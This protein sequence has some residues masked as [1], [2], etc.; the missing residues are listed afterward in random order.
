MNSLSIAVI[1][2]LVAV[3]SAASVSS[4]YAFWKR[5]DTTVC[6]QFYGECLSRYSN[7]AATESSTCERNRNVSFVEAEST[8]NKHIEELLAT[9]AGI[10]EK[11]NCGSFNETAQKECFANIARNNINSLKEIEN[12]SN[13]AYSKRDAQEA[14]ANVLGNRCLGDVNVEMSSAIQEI[15]TNLRSCY[16][17][18]ESIIPNHKWY[19]IKE[20]VP[21]TTTQSTTSTQKPEEDSTTTLKPEMSS[22]LPTEEST[23][24]LPLFESSTPE[25][26]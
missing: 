8:F 14:V 26:F 20:A 17:T 7:Q 6:Y 16:V 4:G 9:I 25:F 22:Q 11:M 5:L 19:S 3:S 21:S 23:S 10:Q 24:G 15:D 2:A 18:G 1:L 12:G 13:Q